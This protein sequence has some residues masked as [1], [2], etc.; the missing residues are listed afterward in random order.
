[1]KKLRTDWNAIIQSGIFCPPV[2]Y[3]KYK[4]YNTQYTIY[5]TEYNFACCFI[6]TSVTVCHTKGGT[7]SEVL[8][9]NCNLAN[10]SN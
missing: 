1:M 6:S 5:V 7:Q 2:W 9:V 4:D 8:I 10:K 3:E